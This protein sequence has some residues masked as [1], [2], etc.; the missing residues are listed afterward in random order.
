MSGRDQFIFDIRGNGNHVRIGGSSGSSR[1]SGKYN[2]YAWDPFK[3][4]S[5][6]TTTSMLVWPEVMPAD[7]FP[8]W[9]PTNSMASSTS[10]RV[11]FLNRKKII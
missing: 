4:S 5:T 2:D 6:A 11:R 10:T 1:D 3:S 8:A 7:T 9:P